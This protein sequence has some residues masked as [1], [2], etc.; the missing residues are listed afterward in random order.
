MAKDADILVHE[1][2]NAYL[3][4]IDKQTSLRAVTKDA[5]V[6]GHSTPEIAG[7]FAKKTN[8][9][10]LL[11]NHFSARYKG[12]TSLESLSIMTRIE[13]QAISASALNETQVAA[14]WDLML[15]PIPSE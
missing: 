13:E 4:G 8:A 10:R 12:D 14:A 7:H 15:L 3:P 6:H 5:I 1:C 9:K 2:T 11:L